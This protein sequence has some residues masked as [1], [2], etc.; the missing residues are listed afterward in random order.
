MYQSV[1]NFGVKKRYLLIDG[2]GRKDKA[3]GSL[4]R[5]KKSIDKKRYLFAM[6]VLMLILTGCKTKE[7]EDN[8]TIRGCDLLEECGYEN[9]AVQGDFK[10]KYEALNDTINRNGKEYRTVSISEGNPFVNTDGETILS[11]INQKQTFYLYI[12]DEMCPW[13][14]SVIEM[15]ETIAKEKN[16]ARIYYIEIWDDEGN[17]IFRDRYGYEKGILNRMVEADSSY[18]ELLD[19]F[20][21]FLDDYT[22][23][24]ENNNEIDVGEKRIY[25]PN[26]F[27]VENG[28]LKRFA[29]GISSLQEDSNEELSPEILE[30]ERMIFTEF[31]D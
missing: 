17:E 20:D 4:L 18:Y 23:E 1:S 24:D 16:I 2:E 13:C 10:A 3:G 6:F 22:L 14:R 27:Y 26:F 21:E 8:K 7:K 31:F 11:L 9:N 29:T 19:L 28:V 25:A 5:R 15:A 12:G 30:D